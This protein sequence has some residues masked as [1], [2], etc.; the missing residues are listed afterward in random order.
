MR[1]LAATLQPDPRILADALVRKVD[2]VVAPN[3]PLRILQVTSWHQMPCISQQCL[4]KIAFVS[5]RHED[6]VY[7]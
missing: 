7:V 3:L 4:V 5:R 1:C 6:G 2:A